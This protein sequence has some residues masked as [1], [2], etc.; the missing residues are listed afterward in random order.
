MTRE[1]AKSRIDELRESITYN[2][3]L[4]YELDAPVI[5]DF[6]Y[7]AMFREL[8]DLEAAFPELDSVTSPSKR[9][10]GVALDKFEKRYSRD[11]EFFKETAKTGASC[12]YNTHYIINNFGQPIPVAYISGCY[13]YNPKIEVDHIKGQLRI[14]TDCFDDRCITV[15]DIK[16]NSLV[17]IIQDNK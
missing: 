4:Y 1:E 17:K 6:E 5:S 15:I 13:K 12:H 16:T 11:I 2:A 3:K 9:V 8:Q 7:D 10:G 14:I